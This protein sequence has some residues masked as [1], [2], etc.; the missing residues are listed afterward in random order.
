[1]TITPIHTSR[2]EPFPK[3]KIEDWIKGCLWQSKNTLRNGD[4]AVL[5]SKIVSYFEGNVVELSTAQPTAKARRWARKMNANPALIQL[6]MNEADSVIAVTPWVL[7]TRKNGIFSSN[8]GVDLSNVPKGYAITWPKDPFASARKIQRLL[9]RTF[10]LKKLA[11]LIIDSACQPGRKGTLSYAIG[12]AGIKGFQD[13]RGKKDLY[14]NILRYSALNIVDSLAT[15]A[16]VMM[17]ESTESFPLAII[18]DFP[19]K[20]NTRTKKDEMVI[21][22]Q[23]EMFPIRKTR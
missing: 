17:G 20:K 10:R 9:L 1:M 2:I 18:R 8:A 12:F 14:G 19:W 5:S 15:A 23:D 4:I 16:N 11:V 6:A 22:S 7:L 3:E 21:S 13:L